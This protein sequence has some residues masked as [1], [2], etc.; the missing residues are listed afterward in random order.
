MGCGYNAAM[1][2]MMETR[3]EG[4]SPAASIY[5]EVQGCI[6]LSLGPHSGVVLKNLPEGMA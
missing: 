6:H 5:R 2:K 3:E 1:V 4:Y